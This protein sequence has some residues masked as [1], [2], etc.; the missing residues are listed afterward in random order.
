[1]PASVLKRARL[2]EARLQAVSSRNIY[3]EHGLEARISPP[4]GDVCQ[5]LIVSW[6]CTPGSAQ[7]QAAR[8]IEFHRSCAGTLRWTAPSSRRV[9]RHS[10]LLTTALRKASVTRTELLAFCPATVR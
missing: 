5:A 10:S 2:S 4:A 7:V 1:K 8:Q 3:S 6:N 9:S